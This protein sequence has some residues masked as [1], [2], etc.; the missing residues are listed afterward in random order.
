MGYGARSPVDRRSKR[1]HQRPATDTRR[2]HP[3]LLAT[4]DATC[5]GQRAGVTTRCRIAILSGSFFDNRRVAPAAAGRGQSLA[6]EALDFE[7]ES[8]D[9][10][11]LESEEVFEDESELLDDDEELSEDLE[12]EEAL[13]LFSRAR[14]RVP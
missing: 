5:D 7:D 10:E 14:L 1:P 11:D 2:V 9:E 8:D 12:S 13:S 6:V 4:G 3:G